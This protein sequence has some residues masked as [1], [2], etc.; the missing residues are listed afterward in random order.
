MNDPIVSTTSV[1]SVWITWF[2]RL[3]PF[4][5]LLIMVFMAWREIKSI[6]IHAVRLAIQIVPGENLAAV[7]ALSFIA[8]LAMTFYDWIAARMVNL[9]LSASFFFRCAWVANTFNNLIGL[10][11]LAG[12]GVR[13]I[14]LSRAHVDSRTSAVYS[15]IVFLS[16]PLGLALLTW[17][18]LFSG[19]VTNTE[20]PVAPWLIHLAMG[21]FAMFV[22]LYVIFFRSEALRRRFLP[23]SERPSWGRLVSLLS[24]SLLDWLLAMTVAWFCMQMAGAQIAINTFTI[25]FILAAI[26]G[27]LSLVP[28][29]LG[30]FDA[31][32]LLLLG[33]HSQVTASQV[34]AGV[35]IF[36]VVYYLVP[37]LIGVY[38]SAGLISQADRWQSSRWVRYW[39]ESTGAAL[40]RLPLNMLSAF[41][42][43][44]LAYLTFGAG[45]V[46]LISAAYPTVT[47]RLVVLDRYFPVAAIEASHLLSVAVA[48]LLIAVSRGIADQVS[49]AYHLTIVLLICGAVFSIFKGIDYEEAS[50]MLVVAGALRLQKKKFYRQAASF[51][52]MRTV[53]W[54]LS[55]L[56]AAAGFVGLNTWIHG[57][58][59]FQIESLLLY[60]PSLE[61]PKF[62]RSLLLASLVTIILIAW[63]AFKSAKPTLQLASQEELAEAKTVLDAHGGSSFAHLTFLGDKHIYWTPQR[64]TFIQYGCIRDRLVALGDPCGDVNGFDEAILGF[65]EFADVHDLVPVFYEVADQHAYRYHDAGFA[66]FKL[67]EMA[68]IDLAEF[69]LAGKQGESLRHSYNK[70]KRNGS[71]FEIL[72]PPFDETTRSTLRAISDAWLT[73]LG[74]A[75][76]GFS[77]GN[78]QES[79]LEL[80]PIAV[81]R[82]EDTIIAF[83]N[84]MPDYGAHKEL[85]VDLMRYLPTAPSGTMD[86]LLVELLQWAKLQN[87]R[88]FNLG[89]APLSGVG[90]ARFARPQERLARFAFEYGNLFYNYKGLRGFKEKFRPKWR[91]H[92][93][94]YPAFTPLP[95][96]LLD[97][98]ALAAGGYWRIFFKLD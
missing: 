88:Y 86:Y 48:I 37:W 4:L 77:L 33:N 55:L 36:R 63:S 75:E 40:V 69:S 16:I 15:A 59:P 84:F 50:I 92:Y 3:L 1:P 39:R 41:G 22:P 8:I 42:V 32:L 89:M 93:L 24:V 13:F 51:K 72:E 64:N 10:S 80:A 35:V 9:N 71:S 17:P 49:S 28:G 97:S 45:I 23:E 47:E 31:T 44:T 29:G 53:Y 91:N 46:L 56:V 98:A 12:S 90:K 94:A 57:E 30:V 20:L 78:Y 60:T 76:K 68:Y 26:F 66:L 58:T 7:Q 5:F 81:I 19:S 67:G 27:I 95:A 2:R 85:S 82:Q 61:A 43:H 83:S 74:V 25:A 6:D 34:L 14:L 21:G 73:E 65:R 52:S 70:A 54:L 18:L 96:L 87:Y 38:L 62:A 11:G 79:Y